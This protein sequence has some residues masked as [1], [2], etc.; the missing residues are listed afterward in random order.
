MNRP[1]FSTPVKGIVLGMAFALLFS[2]GVRPRPSSGNIAGQ[3]TAGDV[4]V[5]TSPETG[6][7]RK[8]RSARMA[9]IGSRSC[10]LAAISLPSGMPPARST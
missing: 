2:A 1:I 7:T 4:V 3:A 9:A 6:L 10:R 8:S 5:A